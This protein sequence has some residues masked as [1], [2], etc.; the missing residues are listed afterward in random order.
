MWKTARAMMR[1]VPSPARAERCAFT[2]R[3][4]MRMSR[5]TSGSAAR[6]VESTQ[7][8]VGSYDCA[9]CPVMTGKCQSQRR[10][11]PMHTKRAED[12]RREEDLAV[13]MP[14]LSVEM[15]K[16]VNSQWSDLHLA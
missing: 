4:A 3:P 16:F 1:A 12:L 2:R 8:P 11:A 9:Q 10:K 5:T 13:K 15:M 14:Q 7:W 6:R